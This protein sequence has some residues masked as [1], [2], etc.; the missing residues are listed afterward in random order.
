[1]DGLYIHELIGLVEQIVDPL[2]GSTRGF[3]GVVCNP[4]GGQVQGV[5]TGLITVDRTDES[6]IRR[7]LAFLSKRRKKVGLLYMCSLGL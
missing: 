5:Q 6:R 7:E 1:M 3:S 2:S 4:E